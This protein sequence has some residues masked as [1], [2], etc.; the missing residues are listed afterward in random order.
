MK[1]QKDRPSM[2]LAAALIYWII[3]ALWLLVLTAV[4]VAFVQNR[5]TFGAVRLLLF[6]IVIDTVRN[7]VENFYFDLYF[8]S[9]Y[10]L[11]PPRMA[12]LLGNPSFL[13][14]PKIVNLVA[15]CAVFGLL[16]LRWLPLAFKE[17]ADA[18]ADV[19]QKTQAL[20]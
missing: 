6:V 14:A 7:V 16:L 13:L 8:G 18:A 17:R 5:R 3:V 4:A 9:R 15:A 11:F 2:T 19:D 1:S 10:G 12:E 20:Y